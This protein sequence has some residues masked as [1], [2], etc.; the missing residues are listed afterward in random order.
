MIH[1]AFFAAKVFF[2][3]NISQT[4]QARGLKFVVK[5]RE[6][7]DR[8][9]NVPKNTKVLTLFI[10]NS[11]LHSSWAF[12]NYRSFFT[13]CLLNNFCETVHFKKKKGTGPP[14]PPLVP[15]VS[16]T[17]YFY[18]QHSFWLSIDWIHNIMILPSLKLIKK[19]F[20]MFRLVKYSFKFTIKTRDRWRHQ[21]R[22]WR[23]HFDLSNFWLASK[24]LTLISNLSQQYVIFSK[25]MAMTSPAMTSSTSKKKI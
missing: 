6:A 18:W 8:I 10:C 16:T 5:D 21:K 14:N 22:L 25:K 7:N 24:N 3:P 9:K 11:G 12:F 13:F 23:H 19:S 20:T 1:F 2:N 15:P 17:P 4:I